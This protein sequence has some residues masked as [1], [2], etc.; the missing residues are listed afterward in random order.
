M[1]Q[2]FGKI[3][4][5]AG[6]VDAIELWNGETGWPGNGWSLSIVFPVFL[7]ILSEGGGKYIDAE[8]GTENAQTFFQTGVCAA[9]D[10]GVDVFYFEAFDE[11]WKPDSLGA[12][13]VYENEK[14]WGAYYSN[15]TAKF[16]MS[17]SS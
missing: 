16:S 2:A 4:E 6:S 10:W 9:L 1:Q 15:R 11:T 5:K 13:N 14:N 3:Q 17:C 7:L 12:N 8:A